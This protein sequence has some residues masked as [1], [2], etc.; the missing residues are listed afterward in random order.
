MGACRL[1]PLHLGEV[2]GFWLGLQAQH[3]L[4][5]EE[6]LRGVRIKDEDSLRE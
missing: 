3:D 1:Q 4:D 5:L 2:V 6:D